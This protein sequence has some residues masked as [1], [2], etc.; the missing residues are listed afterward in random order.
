MGDPLGNPDRFTELAWSFRELCDQHSVRCVFYEVGDTCLTLYIELGLSFSKLGDEARVNLGEFGLASSKRAK[1]RQALSR[2]T[3]DGATFSIVEASGVPAVMADLQRVSDEW[4]AAKGAGEKG[5]SLGYFD[6]DYLVNFDCAVM[7][8]DGEVVAFA[9]LWASGGLQELSIDLMRFSES[10]P[11]GTMDALFTQIML[12]GKGQGY[13]WFNLGMAPLG[14]LQRQALAPAWNK[15]GNV[16]YHFGE[17]FYNFEGLR[18]Y[19]QKFEPEWTP[20]YLASAGGMELPAV[21]M[22][23]TTLISGGVKGVLRR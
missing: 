17:H 14:G 16:V 4:L 20:R 23:S 21:L 3:R 19:K 1:L 22:D 11:K 6:A 10:A 9:N 18:Q 13:Q 15:L 5:F 8:V 2:S 7:R 12:W